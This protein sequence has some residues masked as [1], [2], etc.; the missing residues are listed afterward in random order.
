MML[1]EEGE[2]LLDEP[3][4]DYLDNLPKAWQS[5]TIKHILSHQSGIPSYTDAQNYWEINRLDFSKAEILALITIPKCRNY[6]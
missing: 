3:I 6:P 2:I 4:A 1:V 5:V